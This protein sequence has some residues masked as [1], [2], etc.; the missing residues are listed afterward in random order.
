[1]C[2]RRVTLSKQT[3]GLTAALPAPAPMIGAVEIE[4]AVDRVTALLDERIGLRP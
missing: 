1:L 2:T 3:W 4:A